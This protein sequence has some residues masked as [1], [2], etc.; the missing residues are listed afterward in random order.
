MRHFAAYLT[1]A[2]LERSD[3]ANLP[4]GL[5]A[6]AIRRPAA[7]GTPDTGIVFFGAADLDAFCRILEALWLD[8]HH[9]LQP[10]TERKLFLLSDAVYLEAGSGKIHQ[11]GDWGPIRGAVE[12]FRG[13]LRELLDRLAAADAVEVET[14]LGPREA[15][16]LEVQLP[17]P[18]S[19][20]S[21]G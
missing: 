17:D 21:G 7:A 4:P 1:L 5:R 16:Y 6:L 2:G 12:G 13:Q 9:M 18:A 3:S 14:P 20:A 8:R 11:V 19:P 10:T 15:R